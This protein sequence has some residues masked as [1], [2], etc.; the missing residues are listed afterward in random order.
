MGHSPSQRVWWTPQWL[1]SRY[2]SPLGRIVRRTS[3]L[4]CKSKKPT[5]PPILRKTYMNTSLV[6]FFLVR[7]LTLFA[8]GNH[9]IGCEIGIRMEGQK[10]KF[11]VQVEL[12]GVRRQL[13]VMV[14][15]TPCKRLQNLRW[16]E[17]GAWRPRGGV[18]VRSNRHI[19][20]TWVPSGAG[21]L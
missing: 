14:E 17:S 21:G 13:G 3:Y 18:R 2:L 1:G 15:G 16:E 12:C 4:G 10:W 7:N 8:F 20:W 19:S 9:C 5:M 6:L 11:R